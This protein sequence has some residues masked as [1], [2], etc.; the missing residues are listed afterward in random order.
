[1]DLLFVSTVLFVS[2][3]VAGTATGEVPVKT[4][5][6]ERRHVG[7]RRQSAFPD[8]HERLENKR[9][10]IDHERRRVTDERRI[11][12]R[13]TARGGQHRE[14]DGVRRLPFSWLLLE[15]KKTSDLQQP[16]TAVAAG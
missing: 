8:L 10:A 4:D 6:A 11:E 5:R 15:S 13:F 2:L 1:M 16:L 12:V 14:R 7:D 9:L 3:E